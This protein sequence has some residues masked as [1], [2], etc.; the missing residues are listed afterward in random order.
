MA[1]FIRGILRSLIKLI[2]YLVVTGIAAYFIAQN[3]S[4][5]DNEITVFLSIWAVIVV[6]LFAFPEIWK[7]MKEPLG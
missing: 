3:F 7:W 1:E 5:R 6:L 4:N 2:A